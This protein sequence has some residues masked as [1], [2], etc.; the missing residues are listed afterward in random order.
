MLEIEACERRDLKIFDL[1]LVVGFSLIFG[2]VLICSMVLSVWDQK[3]TMLESFYFFF[4]SLSTVGLGDLVPSSPR[5][6]ITMFGFILIGLSL[7]SMVIN[8]LQTKVDSNYRTFF[9]TFLNL[10]LMTLSCI[11]R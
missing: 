8:L 11:N 2:W 7:V 5:L 4:I 3:W 1:P 10:L 9:P 6:L